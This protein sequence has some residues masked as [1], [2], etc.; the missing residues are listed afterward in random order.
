MKHDRLYRLMRPVR[1]LTKRWGTTALKR[2]AWNAEFR[3]GEYLHDTAGSRRS[4]ISDWVEAYCH[5]GHVLDL[6]CSDGHV[7]LS[8]DPLKYTSYTGVDISPIGIQQAR[9]KCLA[10]Q[11]SRATKNTFIVGDICSYRPEH[12]MDVIL[13]KDSLY[14]VN[15]VTIASLLSRYRRSLTANGVFIV[16]MD[17][18]RRHGWIEG[19]LETTFD[20]QERTSALDPTGRLLVFR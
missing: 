3:R 19:L 16:H 14:Y 2:A 13:F 10:R 4:R 11:D 8:L 12:S 6:G 15:R 17:N 20:I 5:G 1:G 7:A 18:I 9:E